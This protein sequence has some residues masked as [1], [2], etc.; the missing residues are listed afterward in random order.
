MGG[1]ISRISYL[2]GPYAAIGKG[3]TAS[4]AQTSVIYNAGTGELAVDAPAGTNLTSINIESA[5]S[6][7]TGSPS[8]NLGGSFDNDADNNIFKA[9]FGGDFGSLT[10]GNVAQSGLSEDFIAND[11]TVVGSLAGGG[12]L[13][14]VDLIYVPVPEPTTFVLLVMAIAGAWLVR[15]ST[16]TRGRIPLVGAQ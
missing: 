15:R 14:N 8:Q 6:I 4:D 2:T 10:F 12:A 3:G 7:F 5:G 1:S 11:L 16:T 9:T 13:G